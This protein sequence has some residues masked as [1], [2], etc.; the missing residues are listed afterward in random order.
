M[1]FLDAEDFSIKNRATQQPLWSSMIHVAVLYSRAAPS[2]VCIPWP[3]F[4][5]IW[6]ERDGWWKVYWNDKRTGDDRLASSMHL[7]SIVHPLMLQAMNCGRTS[8][9]RT[10][11]PGLTRHQVQWP[12]GLCWKAFWTDKVT[13]LEWIQSWSWLLQTLASKTTMCQ[14]NWTL[15]QSFA[16][17][18]CHCQ[19]EVLPQKRKQLVERDQMCWM[20]L[21]GIPKANGSLPTTQL[22]ILVQ[23][24]Q[25]V[26]AIFPQTFIL[27]LIAIGMD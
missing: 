1:I 12:A 10:A 11:W 19:Y 26:A 25:L 24:L 13:C 14:T 22:S 2:F 27:H 21:L 15:G 16:T 23:D 8:M 18:S 9:G 20:V 5:P 7:S 17:A 3:G 6:G 4:T